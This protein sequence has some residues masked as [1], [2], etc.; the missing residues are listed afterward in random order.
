MH[1]HGDASCTR[2]KVFVSAFSVMNK[3]VR[4]YNVVNEQDGGLFDLAVIH[5]D[6]HATN[7]VSAWL[8]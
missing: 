4:V 3:Y 2:P 7:G 1:A 8:W 6:S 5:V